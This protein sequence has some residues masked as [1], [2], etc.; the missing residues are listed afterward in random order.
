MAVNSFAQPVLLDL[1]VGQENVEVEEER[2][3]LLLFFILGGYAGG[4][5]AGGRIFCAATTESF[6]PEP[7]AT[8]GG[9]MGPSPLAP[10]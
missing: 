9:K 4:C 3:I 2:K 10:R 5:A 1:S 8:A 7:A 6:D